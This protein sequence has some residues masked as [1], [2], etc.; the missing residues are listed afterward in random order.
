[1][2]AKYESKPIRKTKELEKELTK[3]IEEEDTAEDIPTA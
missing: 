2:G 3:K 1:M